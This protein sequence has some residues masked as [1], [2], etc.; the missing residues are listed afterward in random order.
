MERRP[1]VSQEALGSGVDEQGFLKLRREPQRTTICSMAEEYAIEMNDTIPKKHL[2]DI[3]RKPRSG[4]FM[5]LFHVKLKELRETRETGR[6]G[7][8]QNIVFPFSG[9]LRSL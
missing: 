8:T 1:V 2:G 9:G 7:L 6:R 3:V 4:E 5:C